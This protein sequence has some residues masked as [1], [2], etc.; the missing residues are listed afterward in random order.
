M[1]I[2]RKAFRPHCLGF[3]V[4]KGVLWAQRDVSDP[5]FRSLATPDERRD[6]LDPIPVPLKNA[7]VFLDIE[8][9]SRRPL[10][11]PEG[12]TMRY[13]PAVPPRSK[14]DKFYTISVYTGTNDVYVGYPASGGEARNVFRA[15]DKLVKSDR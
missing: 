15:I 7:R 5:A 12:A 11:L 8:I 13:C 3:F 10:D 14:G 9:G 6:Y 4:E 1:G 2:L